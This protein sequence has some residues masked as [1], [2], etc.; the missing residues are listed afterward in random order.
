M[1]LIAKMELSN[2]T[3]YSDPG[4]QY[5]TKF[6]I[7]G[8]G[9]DIYA[10]MPSDEN[11]AYNAQA[12]KA[13]GFDSPMFEVQGGALYSGGSQF[14]G[15]RP[16]DRELVINMLPMNRESPTS[17]K[18][19]LGRMA[20]LSLNDPLWFDV[21]LYEPFGRGGTYMYRTSVY[22][23]DI[24][25]PIL[26]ESREVQLTL[27]MGAVSF[28]HT[29]PI[30]IKDKVIE[31]EAYKNSGY[32]WM[33]D[34]LRT[35]DG[36]R[37]IM[38]IYL[39]DNDLSMMTAPSILNGGLT[40]VFDKEDVRKIRAVEML[41]RRGD[42]IR[43]VPKDNFVEKLKRFEVPGA[44]GYF[45]EVDIVG[46]E[47]RVRYAIDA[48][49]GKYYDGDDAPF[50]MY[51]NVRWPLCLPMRTALT[52]GVEYIESLKYKPFLDSH[53]FEIYPERYGF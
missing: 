48:E 3:R 37:S 14:N 26:S 50:D 5:E 21:Y 8:A 53:T 7:K 2:Q 28:T 49:P 10:G 11:A 4:I 47:R 44:N 16:Q 29:H 52:F 45:I 51:T 43:L 40:L 6:V 32:S 15:F 30:T 27:K 24:T 25:S 33:R 41:N 1:L 20:S 23:S 19:E 17:I 31:S 13:S 18:T 39:S 46:D 38:N 12:I 42:A 34:G 9:S 35:K 36:R 22:I